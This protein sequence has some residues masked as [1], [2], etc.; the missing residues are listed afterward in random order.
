MF[1]KRASNAISLANDNGA[2]PFTSCSFCGRQRLEV[3]K[4]F[5]QDN[6]G[7]CICDEC[8][9]LCITILGQEGYVTPD[10]SCLFVNLEAEW[11]QSLIKGLTAAAFVSEVF[12]GEIPA[13]VTVPGLL[14][15]LQSALAARLGIKPVG[16]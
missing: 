7:I 2:T 11:A 5:A 12:G 15:A 13:G 16:T 6:R 10:G 14:S 3:R 1:G 9:V 8:V 4:L